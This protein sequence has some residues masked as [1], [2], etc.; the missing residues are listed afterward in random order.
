M[1][2]GARADTVAH[3]YLERALGDGRWHELEGLW[4]LAYAQG[5]TRASFERVLGRFQLERERRDFLGER[6][7]RLVDRS[8]LG[9]RER[10]TLAELEA[11]T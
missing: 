1:L 4:I 5:V 8:P 9:A 10:S 11:L 6:F 2:R 7:V 3:G